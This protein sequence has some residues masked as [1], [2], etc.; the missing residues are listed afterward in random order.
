M[1]I[2]IHALWADSD[3]LGGLAVFLGTLIENLGYVDRE[4]SYTVYYARR[5][6]NNAYLPLHFEKRVLWPASS[7]I[8]IPLSLPLELLRRPVDLLHVLAVAP[9]KCPVPFVQSIHDL[10]YRLNPEFYP[11]LIRYR[12]SVL[13]PLT[14]RRAVKI[15]TTSEFSK[16]CLTRLYGIPE[17][18][19][20]VIY[21]SIH[22]KYSVLQDRGELQRFRAERTVP[23]RYILYVGK[24]QARKNIPRLLQA[25]HILKKERKLPHKLVIVGKWTW[26]SEEIVETLKRLDL[27]SEVVF[28][29]E[30]P[31]QDLVFYYNLAELF[32]F[33]SLSEG[34][35]I[36]P[37]EAMAC[38][39]PVVASNA[40]S[41]PEVV[42]DAGMLV[43]PFDVSG[44]AQAMFDVLTST[45]LRSELVTRGFKQV[46]RFSNRRFAEQTLAVYEEAYRKS[47]QRGSAAA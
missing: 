35:G 31:V 2:G 20:V 39:L 29:G 16:K 26:S 24:I 17:E 21:H 13:V 5:S 44:L 45:E 37:L 25:F 41:I 10:D 43:S 30:L 6:A 11:K 23:E 14:A 27:G 8:G 12:L 28:T 15:M 47:R 42:G 40:T 46:A 18:K 19:V 34:F 4:N 3:P 9:P 22:P 32:V 38:G 1:K 33:P 7:W 36:P